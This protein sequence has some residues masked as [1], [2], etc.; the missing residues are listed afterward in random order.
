[1]YPPKKSRSAAVATV[2]GIVFTAAETLTAGSIAGTLSYD[3][4]TGDAGRP[5]NQALS[6]D[7]DGDY[8]RTPLNDLSGSEITVAYWFKGSTHQSIVRQQ[9]SFGFSWVVVGWFGKHILSNDGG[10]DGTDGIATGEGITDG[11]WHHV[12]MTWKQGTSGGWVAYLDG[13]VV[14][15]RD[16]TSIPIPNHAVDTF[17]GSANG[18]SEFANGLIDDIA[19]WNRALDAAE[20]R[21]AMDAPLEGNEAGLVGYWNFDDGTA[22]DLTAAGNHGVLHGDAAIVGASDLGGAGGQFVIEAT[23]DSPDNRVLCLDGVDDH[24]IVNSLTDLSGS[25]I[26]I[27][28]WYR[29]SNHR[30]I[31]R[32]Q[33]DFGTFWIVA[34]YGGQHIL[35][36]DGGTN[37]ISA[38]EGVADGTWHHMVLTWKQNT[39]GGFASYLDGQPATSRDSTNS[40]LPNNGVPLYFGA[41]N[42]AFEFAEGCIDEIAIWSR[43]LSPSE[44]A[45]GWN[46]RLTGNEADLV[47]YWNFD[48]ATADDLTANG[49]HGQLVAGATTMAE[50][51]AGLDGA[52]VMQGLAE[53]GP[54]L[55]EGATDGV[56]YFV[57]AFYDLNGNGERDDDEWRASFPGSPVAV[58]GEV[59]AI[60]LALY[61]PASVWLGIAP[62]GDM[63]EVRWPEFAT[64]TVLTTSPDLSPGSWQ[65]VPGEFTTADGVR[66]HRVTP[67]QAHEFFRL[68]DR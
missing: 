4:P 16:T 51:I 49:H 18:G 24:V 37:G 45:E 14:A 12:A 29:G 33:R 66:S 21:A 64:G 36:N 48:D 5:G 54:Y 32:Q 59:T 47:G 65:V 10:P 56:D 31:V 35:S 52:P 23:P 2:L 30:S 9:A 40:P 8:V 61:D 68:E 43:A 58:A 27:S 22:N 41:A 3:G 34:G 19:I 46:Q 39:P 6:L 28:Y 20:I 63:L 1:M 13:E 57:D 50:A 38:G 17:F 26:T 62:D 7:G 11:S 15:S 67:T 44:V 55:L 60:D 25:E 42:G 53:A